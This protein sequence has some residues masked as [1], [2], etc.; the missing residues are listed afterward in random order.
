MALMV[1]GSFERPMFT[2]LFGP[3]IGLEEEWQAQGA[4]RDE[5]ALAVFDW[6]YVPIVTCGAMTRPR[7][8]PSIVLEETATHRVERDFLG[9]TM[10]LDKR[11]ATIA[12]PQ[13]FPVKTMDDWLKLKPLFESGEDRINWDQ[14][15]NA[16]QQQREGALVL[17]GIP[18]AFDMVRE[19]MGEEM[20]CMAYYDQP[21]LM[22]D[23]I[24]TLHQTAMGVLDQVSSHITIDQLSVHEDLAGRSGPLV[25]PTQIMQYFKPYFTEIWQMLASRGTKMFA[26]DTD[27]NVNA[28]IDVLLECGLTE[29]FP[30]EPAAGMDVVPLRQKYGKQLAFRGGIDKHALRQ[31]KAAIRKELEYK[32]QPAMRDAGHAVFAL[33]HRIPN[34]VSIENYRYY[35]DLGR[36]IL[37]LPPRSQKVEAFHRMAF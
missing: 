14:L 9:R 35:V 29:I 17:A 24:D 15:E 12:L 7:S 10:M 3:L 6:D 33:D 11:T 30:M 34:G 20:A 36:E 2:E 19:L 1:E 16:K 31:D 18:G 25:G 4:S 32:L 13:N 5:I 8:T 26:M 28:I 23:I 37:G 21:E 27:G 22:Q